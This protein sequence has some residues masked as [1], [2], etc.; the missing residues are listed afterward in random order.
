MVFLCLF[1]KMCHM[2]QTNHYYD[3][4]SLKDYLVE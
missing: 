1:L 3:R 2:S 4:A